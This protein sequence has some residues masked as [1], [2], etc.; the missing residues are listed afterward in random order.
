[1]IELIAFYKKN[2]QGLYKT[3]FLS[4]ILIA[5]GLAQNEHHCEN[6]TNSENTG[7]KCFLEVIASGDVVVINYN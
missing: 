4:L 2:E 3:L 7:E 5:V 1:M 6:E